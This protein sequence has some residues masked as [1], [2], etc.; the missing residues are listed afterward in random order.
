M[1]SA[2]S[3]FSLAIASL[4]VACQPADRGSEETSRSGL[5]LTI[6]STEHREGDDLLSAG[7]GLDGLT[8]EAPRPADPDAPD[9][10][11]LR[12]LAIY[13]A[14]NGIYSLTPAGGVGGLLDDLPTIPGREFQALVKVEDATHPIRILVQL[15]DDFDTEKPCLVVA[16]ASGSRGVYGAIAFAGPWALPA[17]CAVA[18]TD[19]GAGTDFFDYSDSSGTGLDGRRVHAD[20]GALAFRPEAAPESDA[21][22][23]VIALPHVH[24]GDNPEADWGHHVLRAAKLGLQILSM[25]LTEQINPDNTRIIAAGLSNGGGAVLRA[26]ELDDQGLLDAVV[27]VAPN[28]TAPEAT[29]LFDAALAGALYQPCLLADPEA[30]ADM[31]LGNPMLAALGEVRCESLVQAG[32]LDA[33]EASAARDRLVEAGF[34]A[35]ALEQSAVNVALDLWR[36]IAA[37]YASAYLR[38]GAFDMPCGYRYSAADASTAQRQSWWATH[39]GIGPGEGI[40]LDDAMAEGQDSTLPGLLCLHE[41]RMGEEAEAERLDQGIEAT[42]A[43][44]EL[45]DIPVVVIHGRDDGLVPVALSSRPYVELSRENGARLAYWEVADAQ[46]FDVLLAAPG[47][48]GRYVPLLPYGWHALDHIGAVLD[49]RQALGEDRRID[50]DPARAGQPLRE[51]DLG[52]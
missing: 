40:V 24:S 45:P 36:T 26:A 11:E 37:S 25:E 30:V 51:A 21:G 8:S 13:K 46:H 2:R 9:A 39:S 47:V 42:R 35:P 6:R 32:L 5:D 23:E 44:A 16:P 10:A 14:W 19:K 49:G 48:A 52:L 33:P 34:D 3:L 50:P 29:P 38:R 31:P 27:A 12:R 17:G 28:I 41:L 7:L 15:P 18:Y 22:S 43:T 4:L 1:M 20:E